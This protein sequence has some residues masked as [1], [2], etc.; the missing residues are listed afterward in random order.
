MKLLLASLFVSAWVMSGY[1]RGPTRRQVH[2]ADMAQRA[3]RQTGGLTRQCG[4]ES[5]QVVRC[6]CWGRT[7][8]Y[9]RIPAAY[10]CSG[11]SVAVP[12]P[13]LASGAANACGT[14]PEWA[15]ACLGE[16]L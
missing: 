7:H 15:S 11:Y 3:A 2:R 12:C 8:F 4:G 10:C 1:A 14:Y 6:G 5:A 16:T 9:V 13:A